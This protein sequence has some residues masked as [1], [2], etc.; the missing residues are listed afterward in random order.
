MCITNED[1]HT[2]F[3]GGELLRHPR[4]AMMQGRGDMHGFARQKCCE[5]KELPS[6]QAPI[7]QSGLAPNSTSGP[8]QVFSVRSKV[9]FT[10]AI[11]GLPA[12]LPTC[13]SSL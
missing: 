9:R 10:S 12:T 7:R 2:G 8:L 6:P 3:P 4:L 13:I 5:R 1:G 11:P